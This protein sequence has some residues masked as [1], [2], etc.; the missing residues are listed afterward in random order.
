VLIRRDDFKRAVMNI[1]IVGC[2][3]VAD[4][5]IAMLAEHPE[6]TLIGV[7]DR[8]PA[9]LM[10]FSRFHRLAT[11]DSYEAML[12]DARVQMVVNLTN[13]SSHFEVTMAALRAGRHVYSE[14]PL[15]MTMGDAQKLVD[16]AASRGLG[17]AAAPCNHL[18][19]AMQTMAREIRDGRLGRVVLAQAEMDDG[20]V[21][22]LDY[23]NW[24]SR[25]GALWP[26]RDEFEVGCTM[27]HAGYHI[28]PLVMLFGAVRR[29]TC[30]N[31]C[32]VPEKG[33]ELGVSVQ[34]P[35]LSVGLLEFDGGVVARLSNSI[36]APAN[37]SLRVIGLDGVATL[38][39]VWEYHSPVRISKTGDGYRPR[40]IRKIEK[41]LS[42]LIPGL[43]FGRAARP[44]PGRRVGK[45][46]G[47]HRMDFARGIAQLAAQI[48][49]A[50]PTLVGPALALHVT[51]VTLALQSPD[52][53]AR[54]V[55]MRT[56]L[57]AGPIANGVAA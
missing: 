43:M 48:E 19:D 11:F 39:D 28:T 36:L 23:Y 41:K 26:A 16:A 5:Y 30:F 38:S 15:A 12:A 6:I 13:P 57:V 31:A 52:A 3:F 54:A 55:T 27:E 49:H 4:N 17:L 40:V 32:Q 24:R 42:P 22:K 34:S 33:R 7:Y 44:V 8:D 14:K 18:S 10:A 29:V 47:G 20:M 25:S 56:D 51:E 21:P 2:G 45:T 1:G 9:R 37:R 53:G 50:A 46:A 35:D